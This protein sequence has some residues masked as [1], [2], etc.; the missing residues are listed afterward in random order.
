MCAATDSV[1][2][3]RSTGCARA[4]ICP[5]GIRR[6]TRRWRSWDCGFC[7]RRALDTGA[8]LEGLKKTL[9]PAR[10]EWIDD[11]TLIDGA[12]NGHGARALAAYVKAFLKGQRIVLVAGMM[13]DKDVA[14]CAAVYA[15]FADAAVAT[16]ISYPRAMPCEE[17]AGILKSHGVAAEAEADEE[18]AVERA[19]ML[20]GADG[21][22]LI[23]GSLYLAG[24]VRLKLKDDGGRL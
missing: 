22:V 20:A 2:I 3:L 14:E 18:K 11:R 8:A 5:A 6:A 21:V 17:L 19:R 1:L 4:S 13:K 12:H 15:T 7:R 23:C 10:L 16:Q 24:D 9:W